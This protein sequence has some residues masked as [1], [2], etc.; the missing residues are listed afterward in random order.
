MAFGDARYG[1]A[2]DDQSF[3]QF[4]RTYQWQCLTRG[5][6]AATQALNDQQAQVWQRR[7]PELHSLSDN[8]SAQASKRLSVV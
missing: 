7:H 3:R 4:L 6:Q 8:E 5:K 1:D 2:E